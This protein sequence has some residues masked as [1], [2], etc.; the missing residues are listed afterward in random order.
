[1]DEFFSQFL[2]FEEKLEKIIPSSTLDRILHSPDLRCTACK[3]VMNNSIR[4]TGIQSD[5]KKM[6]FLLRDAQVSPVTKDESTTSAAQVS[7]TTSS[8][9][10]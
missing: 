2:S 5:V 1:M 9:S 3:N 7:T 4:I 10:M 8:S 6:I